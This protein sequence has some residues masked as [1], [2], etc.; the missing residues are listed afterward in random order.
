LAVHEAPCHCPKP[1]RFPLSRAIAAQQ[2]KGVES[3]AIRTIRFHAPNPAAAQNLWAVLIFTIQ[4]GS[5]RNDE[6]AVY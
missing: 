4:P 6:A 1:N 5:R 3:V 2:A